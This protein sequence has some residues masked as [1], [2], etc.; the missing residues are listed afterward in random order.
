[1]SDE[2]VTIKDLKQKVEK[3]IADREWQQFHSPKTISMNIVR[4]ASELMEHFLWV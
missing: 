1:M 3:F 4:E 2:K